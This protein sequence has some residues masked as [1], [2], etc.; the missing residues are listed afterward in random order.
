MLCLI[1]LM[2]KFKQNIS[3][4]EW[5]DIW[6]KH[7][8]PTN[9]SL[10]DESVI[11]KNDELTI[12][13][14]LRFQA[15]SPVWS[16]MKVPMEMFMMEV[17]KNLMMWLK[18][19]FCNSLYVNCLFRLLKNWKY[20]YQNLFFFLKVGKNCILFFLLLLMREREYI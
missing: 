20:G 10:Y 17:G 7:F 1:I 18:N 14:E 12:D 2:V 5:W 16:P 15:L 4:W 6:H 8:L 3:R 13:P 11:G 9:F 19:T